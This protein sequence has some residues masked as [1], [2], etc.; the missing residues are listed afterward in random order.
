MSDSGNFDSWRVYHLYKYL[1]GRLAMSRKS[2]GEPNVSQIASRVGNRNFRRT[3]KH[4]F[5]QKAGWKGVIESS[6]TVTTGSIVTMLTEL[7]QNLREDYQQGNEDYSRVLNTEDVLI[8]LHKLI[9]LTP[10]ERRQ[11]GLPRRDGLTLLR[12]MLL[13]L[14]LAGGVENYEVIFRAYKEAV[15]L[16]FSSSRET[17]KT[18]EDIDGL[19]ESTVATALDY[20]PNKQSHV[21]NDRVTSPGKGDTILD[22]TLKAK[23]EVRRLLIRSGNTNDSLPDT[24]TEHPYIHHYLQSAFVKKLA[25]TVVSRERLTNQFPIYLKRVTIEACGPLPFAARSVNTIEIDDFYLPL[26]NSALQR[27]ENRRAVGLDSVA[28]PGDHELASQESVKIAVEFYIKVP[29]TYRPAVED[30]FDQFSSNAERSN[31]INQRVDFTLTSTG[32]GGTLS[33]VIK[34]INLMLLRDIPCVNAFFPIAHDVAS[35]QQIIRDNV[36]SPVWAHSLVQL[37]H[38]DAVGEAL[39]MSDRSESVYE[40]NSFADPTGHGDFCGFDFLIAQAQAAL[41]A[42]LQAV[43]DTGV[44]PDKYIAQLCQRTEK[45]LVLDRAWSYLRRYPFSSMAMIGTLHKDVIG[46]ILE[47]RKE[48]TKEDPYICFDAYLSIAEALL[49]EGAYRSSYYYL[50]SLTVL[51]SFVRQGLDVNQGNFVPGSQSFEVFSGALIVRYLICVA[52]YYYLYDREDDLS[53]EYLLLDCTSDINRQV[54]IQKAWAKLEEAQQHMEVRLRKYTIIR[55]P[56]Q[57]TFS[58]HYELL[59]RIYF[60]RAKLLLFFPNFVPRVRDESVLPTERFVGQQRTEASIHWGRLFLIEKARLYTAADGNSEVY[61]CY[62]SMQVY[63]Y[64]MAA[65]AQADNVQL[66]NASTTLSRD[67]C[68]RWARQLRDHALLTYAETGR[69]CYYD[70]KEKSGLSDSDDYAYSDFDDYEYNKEGRYT[71]EKIPAIFEVRGPDQVRPNQPEDDFLTLDISLLGVRIQELPKLTPNHPTQ[72]IYLFGANAC[73]LFFARGLYLLCSDTASEFEVEAPN[74]EIQWDAKLKKSIRLLNMAWA[75]AEDGCVFTQERQE[76]DGKPT[77]VRKITR[78]FSD[79]AEPELYTS[80]EISS[81]RDLYPRRVTELADLGK[82]FSAACMVLRLQIV[83]P[84]AQGTV[85]TDIDKILKMLHGGY[86]L[87]ET[88]KKLLL[89][90]GRYN[91]NLK[92][93]LSNADETIRHYAEKGAFTNADMKNCRDE[94]LSALFKSLL[95]STSIV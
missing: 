85:L 16:D 44:D 11:L 15:G 23:E 20:L 61:A 48:L 27:L 66:F 81:V 84:E 31:S 83:S 19:I 72:N 38:N 80:Q 65:Y 32:V 82:I 47:Q 52:S 49:D 42:R 4:L 89:H 22:L 58:P 55:E 69:Q 57:G 43:R 77:S 88:L 33:H 13:N 93:Y 90:Q 25:Q 21:E 78:L 8:A 45:L 39:Q 6:S 68:L 51:E 60:A 30:I 2:G 92:E 37:C 95:G 46:D 74:V 62:C 91:G 18:L 36:P 9:E 29:I 50:K 54:L 87:K 7:R 53:C 28:G 86:R 1:C 12:Q 14:R 75:I 40:D 71:V 34:V 24:T 94:L 41:Q 3:A 35:T 73:Y 76:V 17:I 63:T 67:G 26:L 10:Q 64:L 56:S 79:E 70:I 5:D 59:G